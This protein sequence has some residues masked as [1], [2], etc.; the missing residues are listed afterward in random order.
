MLCIHSH[1]AVRGGG[2]VGGCTVRVEGGV[3][4]PFTVYVNVQSVYV[5]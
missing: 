4:F 1:L 2:G 5:R 3:V